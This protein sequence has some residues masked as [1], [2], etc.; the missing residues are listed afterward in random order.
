M[1]GGNLIKHIIKNI[2]SNRIISIVFILQ[3]ILSITI[4]SEISYKKNIVSIANSNF[5]NINVDIANIYQFNYFGFFNYKDHKPFIEELGAYFGES[6]VAISMLTAEG[7]ENLPNLKA[8]NNKI[9]EMN[10]E[11]YM[12]DNYNII[13]NLVVSKMIFDKLKIEM[14]EGENINSEDFGLKSL[15]NIPIIASEE[16]KSILK[17][18]D[19]ILTQ[20]NKR[21]II[22]GFFKTNINWFGNNGIKGEVQNFQSLFISPYVFIESNIQNE[23]IF[24]KLMLFNDTKLTDEQVKFK[25]DEIAFKNGI[26]IRRTSMKDELDKI[27]EETAKEINTIYI[28]STITS[29]LILFGISTVVTYSIKIKMKTI[30]IYKVAGFSELRIKIIILSQWIIY[31]IVASVISI[32]CIILKNNTV[33]KQ[34]VYD[35]QVLIYDLA[36][37]SYGDVIFIAIVLTS[38]IFIIILIISKKIDKLQLK[39]LIGGRY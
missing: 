18:G 28:L 36:K 15:D 3:I 25:I 22:K 10:S 20:N 9:I 37:Y 32:G 27:K 2:F 35:G 38:F 12:S 26:T 23:N 11:N 6:N 16:F 21:Y 30:G 29:I 7:I 34:S 8:Y 4:V 13:H 24:N 33:N 19:E 31:M 17:V 5:E 39:E 14:V 1:R